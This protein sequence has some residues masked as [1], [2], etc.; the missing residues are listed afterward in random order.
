MTEQF[1]A[2]CRRAILQGMRQGTVIFPPLQRDPE[3][4]LRR[5]NISRPCADCG[6]MIEIRSPWHKR[7][8]I[9]APVHTRAQK[10][11]RKSA[12]S[13]RKNA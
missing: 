12:S 5:S 8:G 6:I 1:L 3:P 7:C 4:T 2:E 10:R 9:C 11:Q 13:S